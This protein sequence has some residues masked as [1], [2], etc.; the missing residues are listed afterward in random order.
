LN[1]R[2]L[3]S[4]RTRRIP[5]PALVGP[6]KAGDNAGDE[7]GRCP[8][9]GPRRLAQSTIA[10]EEKSRT[11]PAIPAA[12]VS[13]GAMTMVALCFAN[14]LQGGISQ[15]WAQATD[16]IKHSF[17]VNDAILGI[18]PFGV[19]LAGN[20]GAVPIASF[21]ARYKRVLVLATMFVIWGVLVALAGLAPAF[22]LFGLAGAGFGVFAI[23]RMASAV[24]EA[25]DPATYPLISDWWS[26]DKRAQKVSVFNTLSAVGTFVGLGL[27]GVLVDAGLWR[28]AFV[29]WLPLGLVGAFLI[30]RQREPVRGAMDA[31]YLEQLEEATEGEE[32]VQVVDVVEQEIDLVEHGAGPE[33]VAGQLL[34]AVR[35]VARIRSW[36]VAAVG[37]AVTGFIGTGLMN[38]GLAYFK[39]TFHLSG[40][41]AAGLAPVVGI[42]AFVGVL[43]GGF[44][45]DRLL[46]RGML[47]ARLNVTAFAYAGA[48]ITYLFA[49]STTSLAIAAPLQGIGAA[50]AALALG[51]QFAMLMDVAPARLRP[52]ASAALNVLQAT[53]ALGPLLVGGLSTL[54]G[55]NLRLALFCVS[56]FYLLGAVLVL[57]A[58]KTFV[59]DVAVVV[60]DAVAITEPGGPDEPPAAPPEGP[61]R[62]GGRPPARPRPGAGSSSRTAPT[63][64]SSP[65]GSKAPTTS[66]ASTSRSAP[67][68][69]TANRAAPKTPTK[70]PAPKPPGSDGAGRAGR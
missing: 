53:G 29:M 43:G 39:R 59:A 67:N 42:G 38:W 28:V 23:F 62:G 58:G 12:A 48:G 54:F 10:I 22:G 65:G 26:L 18:V 14:G 21:C 8:G 41:Q 25:T 15:T 11:A 33:A 2:A 1:A 5:D 60:G 70:R 68:G 31:R 46:A 6:D 9:V 49:F 16:A 27:A 61:P 35:E 3:R 20:L 51:P 40:T 50:F 45:A 34:P 52:Q 7:V 66:R 37:V 4:L 64:R 56:P 30:A 17:H 36:R 55:E 24:L 44:L 57:T 13:A 69:A 47:R 63:R 19:G 32:H